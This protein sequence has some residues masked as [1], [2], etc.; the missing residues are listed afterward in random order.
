MKDF[1]TMTADQAIGAKVNQLMFRRRVTRKQ[2]GQQ[3]GVTGASVSNKIYGQSK[4]SVEEL[5]KVADFFGINAADLLPR[6]IE[7][8]PE[9]ETSS[10]AVVAGAGFEP[11]TSGL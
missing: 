3:L 4:W 2:L 7:K 10:G 8:A 6:R 9:E 5:F 1:E 11:T